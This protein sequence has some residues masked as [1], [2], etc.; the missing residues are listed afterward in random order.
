MVKEI[1]KLKNLAKEFNLKFDKRW[2]NFTWISKEE[3]VLISYIFMCPYHHYNKYG[4]DC[5]ERIKNIKRFINSPEFKKNSQQ[6]GGQVITF[7]FWDNHL[8]HSI[9]LIKEKEIKKI[10]S[11]IYKKLIKV[12]RTSKKIAL[13][14]KTKSKLE[15]EKLM[16][17][18]LLHEWMH[19]LLEENSLRIN[20]NCDYNEGLVTYLEFFLHNDLNNIEEKMPPMSSGYNQIFN[21]AIKLRDWIG[22]INSSKKRKMK[23]IQWVKKYDNRN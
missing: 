10:Y 9:D 17:S 5:Q 14:T 2:F 4:K 13:L 12:K 22:N 8:P 20:R 3:H 11:S 1:Q 16:N 18:I 21:C 19:V 23:L 15:K 6:I 7:S